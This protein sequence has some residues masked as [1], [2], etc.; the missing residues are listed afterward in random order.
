MHNVNDNAPT[1]FQ[2][3][4]AMSYLRGPMTR[5]QI[6]TLIANRKS[7]LSNVNQPATPTATPFTGNV[8]AQG[9]AP[10]R[11]MP[12]RQ[13]QTTHNPLHHRG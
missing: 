9:L 4:W 5:E 7:I 10:Y 8:G 12:R 2:T 11:V 3:R 13:L 6:K 1:I